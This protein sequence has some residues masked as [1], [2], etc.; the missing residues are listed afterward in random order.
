MRT[1]TKWASGWKAQV[2]CTISLRSE[3]TLLGR[4]DFRGMTMAFD[5]FDCLH[6]LFALL[7]IL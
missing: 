5:C 4:V 7:Y 1:R 2:Q 6:S 3:A